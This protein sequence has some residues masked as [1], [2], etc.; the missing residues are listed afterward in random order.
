M[1]T[2][3]LVG[4]LSSSYCNKFFRG[5]FRGSLE[6]ENKTSNCSFWGGLFS[7]SLVS[8]NDGQSNIEYIEELLIIYL[9]KFARVVK[10]VGS[11]STTEVVIRF[12]FD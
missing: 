10:S 11:P 7:I 2:I 12:S 1:S 8:S 5:N 4:F 6:H 3:G 9:S